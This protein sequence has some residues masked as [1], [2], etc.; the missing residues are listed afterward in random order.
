MIYSQLLQFYSHSAPL[1]K[2]AILLLLVLGLSPGVLS[3]AAYAQADAAA[4]QQ[5]GVNINTAD[6][7]SLAAGLKGIGPSKAAE[8]V[9]YR[10]TYG[11]FA[12]VDELTEVK[13][14]GKATIE[15]NRNVLT[16]E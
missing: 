10:E 16:L 4:S 1:I 2:G 15:K 3:T 14:V 7:Q 5:A 13:G 9:K 12:S 8:I 11:P 6:A